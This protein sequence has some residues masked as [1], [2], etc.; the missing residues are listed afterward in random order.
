MWLHHAYMCRTFAQHCS[1]IWIFWD[2][3]IMIPNKTKVW[4]Q[5]KDDEET[6]S[7]RIVFHCWSGWYFKKIYVFNRFFSKSFEHV[8]RNCFK[9]SGACKRLVLMHCLCD[10]LRMFVFFQMYNKT[11]VW[12]LTQSRSQ[13]RLLCRMHCFYKAL[14]CKKKYINWYRKMVKIVK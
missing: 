5:I 14:F 2:K 7:K 12:C 9:L 4:T 10:T 3:K 6:N 13:F 8:K 11:I 1:I